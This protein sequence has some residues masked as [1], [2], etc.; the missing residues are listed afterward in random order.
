MGVFAYNCLPWVWLFAGRNNIFIW[1]TGWSYRTFNIFHR[2]CARAMVVF[3]IVHAIG[4]TVKYT[5]Y[6]MFIKYTV[7]D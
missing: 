6:C 7:T 3:G 5:V 2:H 1:A 4:Y